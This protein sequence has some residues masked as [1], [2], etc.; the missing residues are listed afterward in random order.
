MRT[1]YLISGQSG[2][3]GKNI[4]EYLKDEKVCRIPRNL[5]INQLIQLFTIIQPDYIIHLG[6]YGNHYNQKDFYKIVDTNIIGT[7]NIFEAAKLID[8][9]KIYN[10]TSSS[11]SLKTPTYYSISKN[12]TEGLST[13][14]RDIVNVRPYSVYG[15]YEA[16]HRFIPTIINSLIN[17]LVMEIDPDATH[18]WIYVEDFIKAMFNGY[19][20]IGTGIKT[21]NIE[22]VKILEDISGKKL[23]YT[24]KH[25]LRGYDNDNW[26]SS[27][28][29]EHRSLY[30]GL[31]LT[32]KYYET[33]K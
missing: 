30:E 27:N 16:K 3:I 4:T 10:I 25:N 31:K 23:K 17:G 18:D 9:K 6:A 33:I 5:D 13:M 7:Y 2:F 20:E 24:I 22:V 29:V 11:I 1:S 12:F 19:T 15:M 26:V 21:T 32:Y 14:Y 28:S 8:Y